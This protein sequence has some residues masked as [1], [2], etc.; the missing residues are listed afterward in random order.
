MD[1]SQLQKK[2]VDE[3]P[4]NQVP[5]VQKEVV[6]TEVKAGPPSVT[7]TPV[8]TKALNQSEE[9]VQTA[10]PTSD[11]EIMKESQPPPAIAEAKILPK[12]ILLLI[13]AC[14]RALL[15]MF[16]GKIEDGDFN[17]GII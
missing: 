14:T 2:R 12:V 3:T 6:D 11:Q 15:F 1:E 7:E 13:L 17:T 9:V 16:F 4:A 10:V 8:T 5:L